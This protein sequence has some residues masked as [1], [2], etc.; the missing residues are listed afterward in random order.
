MKT[1][2]RRGKWRVQWYS[3]LNGCIRQAWFDTNEQAVAECKKLSRGNISAE[4]YVEGA[5]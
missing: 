1:K 4:I 3:P 5:A 2:N